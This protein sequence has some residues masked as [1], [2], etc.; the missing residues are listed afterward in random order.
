VLV[1]IAAG[2]GLAG[3]ASSREPERKSGR[4]APDPVPSWFVT[5]RDQ[6]HLRAQVVGYARAFARRQDNRHRLMLLSFGAARTPDGLTFGTAYR[7]VAGGELV[8]FSNAAVLRVLKAAADAYHRRHRRGSAAIAYGV[9][10]Y[11]LAR[12]SGPFKNMTPD[13]AE[14]AGRDMAEVADDLRCYQRGIIG[15]GCPGP[16]SGHHNRHQSAALGG[17]IEM[18]WEH[19]RISRR[20]VKGAAGP[21]GVRGDFYDYGTAGGCASGPRC[22]NGWTL[23]DV[24]QVSFGFRA[25]VPLPEIYYRYPDQAADWQRV[26]RR[27]NRTH[28]GSCPYRFGGVTGTP[29]RPLSPRKGWKRLRRKACGRLGRELI[30]IHLRGGDKAK[31]AAS[32]PGRPIGE[33]AAARIVDDPTPLF[34]S[35]ELWPLVDAWGTETRRRLT[36]VQAG[37]DPDN[38]SVGVLGIFRQD[39]VAV[40]QTRRVVRVPGTGPLRI[41]DAPR[42]DGVKRLAQRHGKIEFRG[43]DGTTGSL[44]LEDESISQ[45]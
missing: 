22:D 24:G 4:E 35:D 42:G 39:F 26:Q 32:P 23:A 25:A 20:L 21:G 10:N 1:A 3:G 12:P 40:R 44:D 36:A 33:P 13:D 16:A 14:A 15:G 34:S 37:A 2:T 6:E 29:G 19:A 17:D 30:T 41:V 9:T 18:D 27:Y 43:R 8:Y 5:A 31:A 45:E 38:P 11:K 28:R 7:P